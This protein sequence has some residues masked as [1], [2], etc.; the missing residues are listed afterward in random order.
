MADSGNAAS[1]GDK[2]VQFISKLVQLTQDGKLSWQPISSSTTG[3]VLLAQIDDRQLQLQRYSEKVPVPSTV[4]ST[5]NVVAST[6]SSI[7][8]STGLLPST[9]ATMTKTGVRLTV[10]GKD[11]Q[12]FYTF[13]D[14]AGLSDLYE[15]ASYSAAQ[16]DELIDLVLKTS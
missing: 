5:A 12:G 1:D 14:K 8:Q 9:S 13:D 7:A 4:E 16:V 2:T 11:R 6:I 3:N 15:S 10:S